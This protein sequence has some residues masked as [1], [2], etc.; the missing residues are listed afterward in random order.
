MQQLFFKSWDCDPTRLEKIKQIYLDIYDDLTQAHLDES[1]RTNVRFPSISAIQKNFPFYIDKGYL[2]EVRRMLIESGEITHKFRG[3][4][5]PNGVK[6][7]QE[8]EEDDFKP[9]VDDPQEVAEFELRIKA[10]STFRIHDPK[11][12]PRKNRKI[13]YPHR[14]KLKHKVDTNSGIKIS[15]LRELE[16]DENE[17]FHCDE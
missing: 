6:I 5:R 8:D 12:E 2:Q 1:D 16:I 10:A 3:N 11:P 17:E 13:T 9:V 15:F 4:I 7:Y 14:E